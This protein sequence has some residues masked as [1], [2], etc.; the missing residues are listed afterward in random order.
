MAADVCA[1]FF[2][3]FA[4]RPTEPLGVEL[5]LLL[6]EAVQAQLDVCNMSGS[7]RLNTCV[8]RIYADVLLME[9]A[10]LLFTLKPEMLMISSM[11]LLR[12]RESSSFL[13]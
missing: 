4:S 11:L 13:E 2:F 7:L 1:S 5:Q 10:I 12:Q 6:I 3:F 8:K 9:S